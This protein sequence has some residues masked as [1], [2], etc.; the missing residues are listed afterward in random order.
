MKFLILFLSLSAQA[1]NWMPIS[2][3]DAQSNQAY[4]LESECQRQSGEQCLDVGNEPQKVALGF[5]SAEDHY[6][7]ENTESCLDEIDC[8]QTFQNL[9]CNEDYQKIK[10]LDLLQVY[11]TKLVGK[12]LV[13]DEASW[14][15][16]QSA[17]NLASQQL[18]AL[19]QAKSMRQCGSSVM[20]LV[21]VRNAPKALTTEQVKQ[22]VVT[23]NP[24]KSLLETGSLVT[25]KEEV[26]AISPDG[27]II[28]EAD[29]VAV[30]AAIDSCLGL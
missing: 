30:T 25:A 12:K 13:L 14:Q 29:K 24:I 4:Q 8:E 19:N 28:T 17:Q 26:Q 10:N 9:S 18:Q 5:A 27:I 15:A 7:K 21:L 1:S 23:M 11:C 3:I 22:L 20:D 2:K 16:Y 6:L